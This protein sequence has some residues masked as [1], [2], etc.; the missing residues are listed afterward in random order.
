MSLLSHRRYPMIT[1]IWT[2]VQI[3]YMQC[4]KAEYVFMN[5][6]AY[7]LQI[8]ECVCTAGRW[9]HIH[10]FMNIFFINLYLWFD[11]FPRYH[12]GIHVWRCNFIIYIYI[13]IFHPIASTGV[14][15]FTDTILISYSHILSYNNCAWRCWQVY[16]F[17]SH[18]LRVLHPV[19][20]DEIKMFNQ[21]IS[22]QTFRIAHLDVIN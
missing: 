7:V 22:S 9:I 14:T 16:V 5:N 19:R 18:C 13:Y 3:H 8:F 12:A 11:I 2:I 17:L 4:P 6:Q 20:N 1:E 21:S 10:T 15:H